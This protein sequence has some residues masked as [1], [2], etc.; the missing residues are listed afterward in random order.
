[1]IHLM[2]GQPTLCGARR[3]PGAD[4][5]CLRQSA[6]PGIQTHASVCLFSLCNFKY[7][8]R[9]LSLLSLCKSFNFLF[10]CSKYQTRRDETRQDEKRAQEDETKRNKWSDDNARRHIATTCQLVSRIGSWH[11]SMKNK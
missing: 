5:T 8:R 9:L 10:P 1:M 2:N 11:T 6:A 3:G 7:R 4:P